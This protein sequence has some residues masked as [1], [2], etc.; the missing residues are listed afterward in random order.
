VVLL[1]PTRF[2]ALRLRPPFVAYT[3]LLAGCVAASNENGCRSSSKN[4]GVEERTSGIG[5]EPNISPSQ[6]S[7]GGYQESPPSSLASDAEAKTRELL[8]SIA[9]EYTQYERVDEE[10]RWG[11]M[12]CSRPIQPPP[13]GLRMSASVDGATHGRKVYYVFT[14]SRLDY[15]RTVGAT[16]HAS[17]SPPGQA[18]VKESWT[19]EPAEPAR[20]SANPAGDPSLVMSEGR[21]FRAGKKSDLF[22][23]TKVDASAPGTDGGWIYG[24]V[25]A[26]GKTVIAQGQIAACAGCH[27]SAP[28][29]RLFGLGPR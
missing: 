4:D 23:M 21:Y 13:N 18:I 28:H 10:I 20:G 19:A 5:P 2:S 15:F 8:L 22:I 7:P 3:L 14:K 26:D 11:L 24:T 25:S 17:P 29:D 12:G 6:R 9:G 1:S 27:H 16:G